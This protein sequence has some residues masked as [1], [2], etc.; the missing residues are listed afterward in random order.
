MFNKPNNSPRK[1][2]VRV[3]KTNFENV[4][5]IAQHSTVIDYHLLNDWKMQEKDIALFSFWI[6]A[7]SF[8]DVVYVKDEK[9]GNPLALFL[10]EKETFLKL[11]NVEEI[12]V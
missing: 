11:Y 10:V 6:Y 3:L 7:S 1:Q 9:N 2:K 12:D 8:F 4:M 5:K